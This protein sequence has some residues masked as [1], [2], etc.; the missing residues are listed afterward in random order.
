MHWTRDCASFSV[1]YHRP[2]PVMRIVMPS[3][4][5]IIAEAGAE[6]AAFAYSEPIRGDR[7]TW[8]GKAFEQPA[9]AAEWMELVDENDQSAGV[10]LDMVRDLHPRYWEWLHRFSNVSFMAHGDVR[11]L[12]TRPATQVHEDG[13][14]LPVE[15]YE[16]GDGDFVLYV[17]E[18]LRA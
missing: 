9:Q 1:K 7:I 17:P 6:L 13:P 18:L 10:H 16:S 15:A 8:R 12:F 3:T 4:H 5:G 11:I 14:Y 2:A